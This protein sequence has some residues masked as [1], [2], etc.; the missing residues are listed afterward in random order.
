MLFYYG[1]STEFLYTRVLVSGMRKV[2]FWSAFL[3]RRSPP[4]QDALSHMCEFMGCSQ[5][6]IS[7]GSRELF[8]FRSAS[9]SYSFMNGINKLDVNQTEIVSAAFYS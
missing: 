1:I 9:R 7:L 5:L 8:S 2:D 6:V 3:D 4:E